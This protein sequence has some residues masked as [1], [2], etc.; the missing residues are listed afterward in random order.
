MKVILT[1]AVAGLGEAGNIKEVADGYA[2]NFLIPKGLA[3]VATRGSIKQAEQQ[4]E[5]YARRA[6]KQRDEQQKV[7]GSIQDKTVLIRARAGAENR[8]YGSVT[9]HDVA[10]ALLAQHGITVD[11]RKVE[12]ETIHRLGTY[13]AKVDIGGG[14]EATFHVEVASEVAG[15]TGKSG[16]AAVAEEASPAGG[17][18]TGEQDD[19]SGS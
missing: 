6:S 14:H 19:E 8:L 15:A 12:V 13:E 3:T 16:K 9:S 2:R 18:T 17:E 4:A 7:A 11:R 1:Q 10:E 5:L